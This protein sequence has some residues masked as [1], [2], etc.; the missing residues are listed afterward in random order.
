M[1]CSWRLFRSPS[2]AV[3]V[4][5]REWILAIRSR[6][7]IP[8]VSSPAGSL[9]P[10]QILIRNPWPSDAALVGGTSRASGV[11]GAFVGLDRRSLEIRP[12]AIDDAEFVGSAGARGA[13]HPGQFDSWP[14]A[15]RIVR[16]PQPSRCGCPEE[17]TPGRSVCT[18]NPRFPANLDQCLDGR[19][20][21]R[22]RTRARHSISRQNSARDRWPRGSESGGRRV[23]GMPAR[24]SAPIPSAPPSKWRP[25]QAQTRA[26]TQIHFAVPQGP[27]DIHNNP[28][29]EVR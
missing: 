8:N 7:R 12:H 13:Q 9:R 24:I 22:G 26:T 3:R 29:G 28:G 1:A 15:L 25:F 23:P 10:P 18:A 2:Q 20:H 21:T 5:D 11:P 14:Q 27:G 17:S 16:F 4:S 19:P 6:P